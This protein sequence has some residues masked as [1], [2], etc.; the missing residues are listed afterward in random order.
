MKISVFVGTSLDGFIARPNGA[1]DFLTAGGAE[2]PGYEEFIGT[3]D[4]LVVGRNTFEQVAAFPTWPYKKKMRVVVLSSRPVEVTT[5]SGLKAEQMSGTPADIVERLA[6]DGVRHIYVD[7]GITIQR[8][9]AAGLV[10]RITV[11]RIPVL[12]GE[13]I[14]LFGSVPHDVK[15]RH[16][17]TEDFGGAVRSEYE[18]LG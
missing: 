15:L 2:P 1:F 8:F 13:G 6:A 10:N 4:C 3:V 11:T 17:R 7:G 5:I 16:L 9:L 12:I 18:V 14:P